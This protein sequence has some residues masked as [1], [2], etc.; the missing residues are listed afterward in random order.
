MAR[1]NEVLHRRWQKK[2]LINLS[3]AECLPHAPRQNLIRPSLVSEI[4]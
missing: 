2:R 4:Y 3:M 1:T